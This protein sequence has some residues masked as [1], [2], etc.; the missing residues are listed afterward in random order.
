[1]KYFGS[2]SISPKRCQ[3]IIVSSRYD[4][5]RECLNRPWH[6]GFGRNYDM[7]A[8]PWTELARYTK[9]S[10]RYMGVCMSLLIA[11]IICFVL[12]GIFSKV[13]TAPPDVYAHLETEKQDHHGHH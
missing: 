1:M 10:Y 4:S 6:C 12:L 5:D 13:L 7:L 8:V 2:F 11:F 9:Y 3:A